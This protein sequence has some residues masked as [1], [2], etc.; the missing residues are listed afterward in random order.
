MNLAPVATASACA[1]ASQ[2]LPRFGG[3]AMNCS[4]PSG[5]SDWITHS[6]VLGDVS[7]N[8]DQVTASHRDNSVEASS[9]APCT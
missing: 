7:R 8:T 2:V 9:S 3:P 4:A 1:N 5:R 6:V